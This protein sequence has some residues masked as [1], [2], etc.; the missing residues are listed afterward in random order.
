MNIK[1]KMELY[2]ARTRARYTESGMEEYR[3]LVN[4]YYRLGDISEEKRDRLI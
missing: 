1:I 3:T 2:Q 4:H